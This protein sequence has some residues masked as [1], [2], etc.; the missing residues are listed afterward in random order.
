MQKDIPS[1]ITELIKDLTETN[2]PESVL[3]YHSQYLHCD[4]FLHN[5]YL[6][7]G[8]KPELGGFIEIPSVD[9]VLSHLYDEFSELRLPLKRTYSDS[10]SSCEKNRSN[11]GL[12]ILSARV[13]SILIN[14]T[15]T[16]YRDVA[17]E[18]IKE[19]NIDNKTEEKNILRRVYDSLNVLIAAG[20]VIK[21][22]KGY[23]W[24]LNS[25][26]SSL[27]LKKARLQSLASTFY[28]VSAYKLCE[29]I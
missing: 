18:L 23:C 2:D 16:S 24:K 20:V 3:S 15:L 13:K 29:T 1:H 26:K 14:K 7:L 27:D 8:Y 9:A 25:Q 19:M 10:S 28:S 21:K 11:K 12:K 6:S 4:S 5:I 22:E 17:Q